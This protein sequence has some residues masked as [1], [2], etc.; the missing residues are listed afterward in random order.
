MK[1]LQTSILAAGLTLSIG[2]QAQVFTNY[3][4][5]DGLL[6]N[7]V[8]AL[9]YDGN[10]DLWFG[11]QSGVSQ[12]DGV[13]WTDHT[14]ATDSGLVDNNITAVAAGSTGDIWV[15]SDFGV[16]RYSGGIWETF[17]ELDGLG[18]DQVNYI[19]DDGLGV[20]WFGTNSGVS[21]YDGTWTSWGMAE[22]LPFGGVNCIEFASN[23]DIYFGGGLGGVLIFDGANFTELTENGDE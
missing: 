3:S 8:N 22:G 2:V 7:N 20:I 1:I 12:F 13:N 19:H 21:K 15:G 18:D 16:S 14:T 23:G 4:D 10:G 6:N 5:A 11:T 9:D 17:T